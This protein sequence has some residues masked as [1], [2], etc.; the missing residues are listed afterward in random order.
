MESLHRA[1]AI[2]PVPPEP[3]SSVLPAAAGSMYATCASRSS[4]RP[5]RKVSWVRHRAP[6][7]VAESGRR[8][9]Q[10]GAAP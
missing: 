8:L 2:S 10:T 3:H 1:R 9:L 5:M 4:A 6:G 7:S